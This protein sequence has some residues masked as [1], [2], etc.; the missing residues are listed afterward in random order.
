MLEDQQAMEDLRSRG[1]KALPV[2]I[3]DDTEVIIGYFPKKL[4]TAF[5]LD[6]KVDLSGKTEWLA[7]KYEKILSAACRAA[8]QFSH[9]LLYTSDAADE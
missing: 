9:C 7:E 2:T 6:V 3:I 4:I 5:K 1:I 8:A